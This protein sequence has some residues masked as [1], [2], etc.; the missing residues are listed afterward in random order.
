[1]LVRGNVPDHLNMEG[2]LWVNACALIH[3]HIVGPNQSKRVEML[4]DDR[5]RRMAAYD[6][7]SDMKSTCLTR[8]RALHVDLRFHEAAEY[9]TWTQIPVLI[10]GTNGRKRPAEAGGPGAVVMRRRAIF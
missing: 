5:S 7:W 2:N 9:G 4:L 8:I 3:M 6:L 10:P 1:M